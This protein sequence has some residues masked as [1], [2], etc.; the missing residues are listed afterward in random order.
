MEKYDYL[1]AMEDILMNT[2]IVI[3]VAFYQC[4]KMMN[5]QIVM[6]KMM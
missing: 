4:F 6:I 5:M 3:K 1:D 2:L